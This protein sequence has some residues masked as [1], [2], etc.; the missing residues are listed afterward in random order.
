ALRAMR[1]DWLGTWRALVVR[2]RIGASWCWIIRG[3]CLG[4]SL[5]ARES[6]ITRA[7][8]RTTWWLREA[9]T[10]WALMR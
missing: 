2:R 6:W 9:M 5:I 1:R 3:A 4:S 8:M 7:M 10:R